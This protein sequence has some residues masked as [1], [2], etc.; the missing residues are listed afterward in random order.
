MIILMFRH[1]YAKS[2]EVSLCM[3]LTLFDWGFLNFK[4]NIFMSYFQNPYFHVRK[5]RNKTL[6]HF[7]FI[8]SACKHFNFN[9][10]S[11][12]RKISVVIEKP[13]V[14]SSNCHETMRNASILMELGSNVD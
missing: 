7:V 14:T 1:N 6:H 4:I 10:M 11:I 12:W 3:S 8:Q 2:K 9:P 13:P 5:E